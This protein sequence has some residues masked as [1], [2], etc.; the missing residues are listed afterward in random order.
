MLEAADLIVDG[1]QQEIPQDEAL[2]SYEGWC[3]DPESKINW[4]S[5][6]DLTYNLIRGCN[7][8]PGAWTMSEG[9]KLRIF[10]TRRHPARRFADVSGKPGEIAAIGEQGLH[11]AVQG[12]RLEILKLRIE[13][14][15]KMSGAAYAATFGLIPGMRID[16]EHAQNTE[17]AARRVKAVS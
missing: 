5:H 13:G 16:G 6:L 12:G 15:E 7:P 9:R 10:D 8:A 4:Y 14:G 2:A 1:R 17:A 11:I 3:K